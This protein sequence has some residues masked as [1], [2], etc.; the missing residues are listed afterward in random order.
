MQYQSFKSKLGS[1]PYRYLE[2]LRIVIKTTWKGN[3]PFSL[4]PMSNIVFVSYIVDDIVTVQLIRLSQQVCRDPR[5]G[6]SY[7]SYGED[8]GI[9]RK[10]TSIVSGLQGEPPQGHEKGYPFVAGRFISYSLQ[11]CFLPLHNCTCCIFVLFD[12]WV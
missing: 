3:F 11:S 12:I 4:F 7:E 8:T 9:V 6:R 5:W 1:G 2:T 10:M